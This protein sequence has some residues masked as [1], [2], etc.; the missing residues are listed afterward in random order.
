[1]TPSSEY[2]EIPNAAHM[3]MWDARKEY[4]AAVRTF[5]RKH[6]AVK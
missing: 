4:L 3:T 2:I 5:L 1:M 6:D